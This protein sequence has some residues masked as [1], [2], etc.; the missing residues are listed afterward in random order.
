[1]QKR[2]HWHLALA[3]AL[4]SLPTLFL[5]WHNRDIPHFG[6]LQDDGLYL[7]GAKTLAEGRPYTIL[8][9]PGEPYQTKYPPIYPLYL[10]LAWRLGSSFSARLTGALL[11]SWL[12]LPAVLVLFHRWLRRHDFGG[13]AWVLTAMLAVQ[14]YVLFFVSNLGSELLFMI[15]MLAAILAAE[16]SHPFAGGLLAGLAYLT[17]T[18]GLMLLPAAIVYFLLRG[19]PRQ[20]LRFTLAMLPAITAWTLWSRAHL[21]AAHDVVTLYYTNYL[22]YQ[23][24]N[25]TL[26]NLHLV[27]WKNFSGM[28]ESFGSFVFPQMV[29]GILAKLILQPLGLAMIL[30]CIR[31]FRR[32]PAIYPIFGLLSA[33]LLLV[34]HGVPNQRLVLPLAPLLLAGFWTEAA[35]FAEMV[36]RALKHPDRS[37]RVV[38]YAFTTFLA[39]V[40]ATGA[41]LQLYMWVR[42]EP[43]M[44]RDDRAN[45][46]A[47]QSVYRWIAANTP[48]D[49][50]ILW[51][52]DT[53]L[54]FATG[55]HSLALLVPAKEWYEHETEGDLEHF[56]RI[57]EYAREHHLQYAILPK[58]G[59]HRNDAHLEA[60]KENGNLELVHEETG[61][62]V[63]RLRK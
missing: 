22:G 12:C 9:A 57:D 10:S 37:Q 63:Y 7:I 23:L 44:A 31:M 11:L 56:R 19:R 17:R 35:H 48:P 28:L 40:L 18:A 3:V 20:A 14:P 55:R 53:A 46:Q 30:G 21:P 54:Y 45:T 25:V 51:E 52:D 38:A 59:P 43:E 49:A 58:M 36:R 47:F 32:R 61:G 33:A 34:W 1:M 2:P 27:V 8:S 60:L 62:V 29:G 42:I 26:S 13:A 6:V 50:N 15:F 4:L 16:D 24:Y 39:L 41:A 5:I